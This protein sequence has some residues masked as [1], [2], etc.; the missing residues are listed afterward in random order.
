VTWDPS[1]QTITITLG[2][3]TAGEK[4]AVAAS[5]PSFTPDAA[6]RDLAGNA[7]ASGPFTGSSSAF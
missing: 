6:L 7:I 1:S 2:S 4:T 5:T 3:G